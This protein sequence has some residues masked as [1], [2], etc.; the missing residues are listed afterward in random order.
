[1]RS[2]GPKKSKSADMGRSSFFNKQGAGNFFGGGRSFFI[3]R[4]AET[5]AAGNYTGNYTFNPG[6]DGL[7]R[8]FFYQVKKDVADGKLDDAE[9]TALRKEAIDRNGTVMHAELLLMAAMRNAANVKLM[10]AYTSGSLVIPMS[11]ISQADEDYL[12]NFG[13][14]PM[15]IDSTAYSLRM[16][17]SYLG[18]TKEKISDI[19]QEY[20]TKATEIVYK[21][22]GKQFADQAGRLIV[23]SESPPELNWDDVIGAMLNGAADSTPGDRVM[24]GTV[25]AV[26]KKA[27]HIMAPKILSGELKIDALIP[28]VYQR[29]A[30]NGEASY[31]YSTDEDVLKSDTFYVQTN[32]DVLTLRD[33]ALVIHELT[34]AADDFAAA[35]SASKKA[36]SL[37]L[38]THA[39][40]EQGRYM[41][42]QILADPKAIG[43]LNDA[44][45]YAHDSPLYY[46]AMVA[47]AKD[48][49]SK[50]GATLVSI[51]THAP[52]S[53]SAAAVKTDLGLS[54]ADLEKK[55][56]AEL[57]AYRN[58]KGK[59]LYTAGTTTIGG[60]AGHYFHP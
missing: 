44:A 29:V 18:F 45:A 35:G 32:L 2:I 15:P 51:I 41:M 38:E 47:A 28:S 40:K 22:A 19:R 42:D 56:R 17:F 43:Y 13:S 27:G 21:Y 49:E 30:G 16:I 4:K 3:Q 10:Q 9:I 59:Q 24:A 46:W 12:T 8:G 34:H 54:A 25:Y 52:M 55:V 33:Q 31:Q 20:E 50:Y 60:Q 6:H 39:Y 53:M 48:N 23:Y 36:D 26:A 58:K 37:T 14:G 7:D 1:M 57:V 5:N 11:Q